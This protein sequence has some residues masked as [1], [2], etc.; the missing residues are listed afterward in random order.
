MRKVKK[1]SKA[2]VILVEFDAV[3]LACRMAEAGFERDRPRGMTAGEAL[4]TLDPVIKDI[5][6]NAAQA[7]LDYVIERLKGGG[8]PN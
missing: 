4:Q 6:T 1:Q 3:E 7:A 5:W 8:M 2:R